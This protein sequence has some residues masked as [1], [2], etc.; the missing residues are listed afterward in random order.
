MLL[1][2]GMSCAAIAKVLF[3]DDDTIR[4]WCRLYQDDGIEGSGRL[5]S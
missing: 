4:G 2:G 1:D 3:L 5:W